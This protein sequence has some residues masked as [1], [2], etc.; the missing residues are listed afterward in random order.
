MGLF[1]NWRDN[2][3]PPP[4]P[5]LPSVSSTWKTGVADES[6]FE[7]ALLIDRRDRIEQLSYRTPAGAPDHPEIPLLK[8]LSELVQNRFLHEA[9]SIGWEEF[10]EFFG[11]D[12]D[13]LAY[14]NDPQRPWASVSLQLF[15]R[16]LDEYRG[17]IAIAE[18]PSASSP[19]ICR[20]FGIF[21]EEI[22]DHLKANSGIDLKTLTAQ[23]LAG[24]GC[25]SCQED[26]LKLIEQYATVE[27]KSPTIPFERGRAAQ[28]LNLYDNFCRWRASQ[29]LDID[30]LDLSSQKAVVELL[31]ETRREDMRNFERHLQESHPDD[32]GR[33]KIGIKS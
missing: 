21:L 24:G 12:S 3:A 1:R 16:A 25:T 23:L 5:L 31:G 11:L 8:A 33:L 2:P 32:L 26:L 7:M 9:E 15:Y 20:C 27:A 13:Y 28:V 14:R 6:S 29:H 10:D 17:H 4:W 18:K 30:I 19:L 22:T